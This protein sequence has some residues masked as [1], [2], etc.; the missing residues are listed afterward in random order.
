MSRDCPEDVRRGNC[1][2]F[3]KI[4]LLVFS[5]WQIKN[6]ITETLIPGEV[7][8]CS[9]DEGKENKKNPQKASS[10]DLF[11]GNPSLQLSL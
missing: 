10:N 6:K 1:V 11:D 9:N 2:H 8:D 3:P 5:A 4:G 7:N